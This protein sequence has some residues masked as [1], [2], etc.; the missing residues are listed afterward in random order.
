M[1]ENF[2]S[3]L[4][5][6]IT[7]LFLINA[8]FLIFISSFVWSVFLNMN[9]TRLLFDSF[10]TYNKPEILFKAA[11]FFPILLIALGAEY[12][13]SV[14]T[15][16]N[17]FPLL[18]SSFV[19]FNF[20]GIIVSLIALLFIKSLDKEEEA[21]EFK[22]PIF[23]IAYVI[24]IYL[25]YLIILIATVITRLNAFPDGFLSQ[26]SYIEAERINTL[27]ILG[28][29]LIHLLL[30]FFTVSIKTEGKVILLFAYTIALAFMYSIVF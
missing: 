22:V 30:V 2:L 26:Y 29:F 23:F 9:Q 27:V 17:F 8:F 28:L 15:Q 1:H 11:F 20:F 4:L 16:T 18:T 25:F 14:L 24:M 5:S 3:I 21:K 7:L 19:R 6:P 12:K 10:K 13:W